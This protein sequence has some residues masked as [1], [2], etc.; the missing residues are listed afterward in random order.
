MCNS[1]KVNMTFSPCLFNN[2]PV[3]STDT[4]KDRMIMRPMLVFSI[5]PR[6]KVTKLAVKILAKPLQKELDV[7][8]DEG[9]GCWKVLVV[10]C[11]CNER[12]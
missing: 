11:E 4:K 6:K 2:R 3:R 7:R 8:L 9:A 5:F 10:V 1:A 12:N